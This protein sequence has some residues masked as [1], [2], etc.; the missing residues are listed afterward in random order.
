MAG[1]WLTVSQVM[2]VVSRD[3]AYYGNSGGGVTFSGGEP[4]VQPDFLT[5]CFKHCRQLGIHTALDTCGYV[6]GSVLERLLPQVDLF[7]FD[8]KHM[9]NRQHRRLTG[10]GNKR[11]LRNLRRIDQYGK[12]VWIRVPLIPG[13]NDSENNLREI[14]SL[15]KQLGAVKKLSLL[16]YNDAAGAK[17]RFIGGKYELDDI[18]RQPPEREQSYLG[19]F[20]HLDVA[21]ELGR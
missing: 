19:Y 18:G 12:P 6:A 11:I 21:V 17:Y 20:S 4:A 8:I 7:L 15:I 14:A 16:P 2:D 1:K 5:A 10:V 3:R 9:D 13:Y